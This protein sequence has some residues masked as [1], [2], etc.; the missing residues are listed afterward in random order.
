[1]AARVRTLAEAVNGLTREVR[2]LR[3]A[4]PSVDLSKLNGRAV[5]VADRLVSALESFNLQMAVTNGR[6]RELSQRPL[7]GMLG[8]GAEAEIERLATAAEAL[9]RELREAGALVRR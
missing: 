4:A 1:M 5:Q 9:S 6:L 3:E 7:I 8:G 2:A